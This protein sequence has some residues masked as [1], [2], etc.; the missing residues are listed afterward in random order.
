MK[1][2]LRTQLKKFVNSKRESLVSKA[3]FK[4][5]CCGIETCEIETICADLGVTWESDSDRQWIVF[6]KEDPEHKGMKM[7]EQR[8][9][10]FAKSVK[11]REVSIELAH[12]VKTE[13]SKKKLGR[14]THKIKEE[15]GIRTWM[16]WRDG[17]LNFET[18]S[19]H[20]FRT[21]EAKRLKEAR[22]NPVITAEEVEAILLNG[23]TRAVNA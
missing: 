15:L 2:R 16:N 13:G 17:E 4:H 6:R 12:L 14:L 9:W 20:Q 18:E 22:V 7:W 19:A 3:W 23:G 5:W 1:A 21:S 10:D 8:I 11:R